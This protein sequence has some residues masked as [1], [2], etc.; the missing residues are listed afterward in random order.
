MQMLTKRYRDE[1]GPTDAGWLKSMHSFSFGHYQDPDHMGFGPLRVINE[2]RVVPGAG[3]GAHPHSNMEIISYV[4]KGELAHKDSMGNG[5]TIKPGDIQIM[6]AGSGIT[7]SEYNGSDSNE[8]H[9]LQIWIMPNVENEAPD[10]QQKTFD[11]GDLN[12]QFRVVISP[13]GENGSLTIKQD[14]RMLVGKFDEGIATVFKTQAG[15]R[16]WIQIAQGMAD[17]NGEKGA[18]GDGF[19]IETENEIIIK[20]NTDAEILLF[21]LP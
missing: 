15:R 11:Q 1:R 13:D 6:S 3:F 8:V 16:Y 4:L 10:Y 7:H 5:S 17:V 21:D 20:A 12:N 14:A 9:F 19:A 2:D 18:S